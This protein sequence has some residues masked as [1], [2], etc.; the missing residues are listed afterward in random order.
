MNISS[1]IIQ[2]KSENIDDLVKLLK[3]SNLCDYH[4]HDKKK[5]KIIITIEALN[6]EA[7]M[8]I[9][10]QIEQIPNIISADMQM[11]YSEDE[12]DIAIKN[13][14]KNIK[15]GTIPESLNNDNI[16][17]KDIVYNGNLKKKI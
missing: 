5:G 15:D 17:A 16:K 11:S 10:K 14:E 9:L 13:I 3:E 6:I 2:A 7:E 4:F 1:V 8:N 12:L